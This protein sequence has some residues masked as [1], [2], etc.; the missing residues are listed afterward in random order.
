M[1]LFLAMGTFMTVKAQ[2]GIT[3]SGTSYTQNFD[4]INSAAA[5]PIGWSLSTTAA[6]AA[7]GT[8][9]TA[10]G[11][12]AGSLGIHTNWN[13][14]N[15]NQP[16]N[17]ASASIG[18][19]SDTDAQAAATNRAFGARPAAANDAAAQR[20]AFVL[21]LA[22]TLGFQNFV[23]TFQLQS[24]DVTSP[25][26]L[27]WVVQYSI[28]GGTVWT[29]VPTAGTMTTGGNT[30]SNNAITATFDGGINNV[31]STVHIRI[32]PTGASTGTGNRPT[33]AIDDFVLTF[34]EYIPSATATP[35][36][37]L[38]SG[39]FIGA[40]NVT[41]SSVTPGAEIRFTTDGSTPDSSST[42]FENPIVVAQTTTI[43]AIAFSNDLPESEIAEATFTIRNQG[44]II[45]SQLYTRGGN[46]G[47]TYRGRFVELFNTTNAPIN[48][49]GLYIGSTNAAGMSVTGTALTGIIPAR[50]FFFIESAV[51]GTHADATQD[52]PEDVRDNATRIPGLFNA[53]ADGQVVLSTQATVSFMHDDSLQLHNL[54]GVLDVVSFGGAALRPIGVSSLGTTA[55]ANSFTRNVVNCEFVWTRNSVTGL[56]TAGPP[57]FRNSNHAPFVPTVVVEHN[58]VSD[59]LDLDVAVANEPTLVST[60]T[61]ILTLGCLGADLTL[62]IQ[63][64]SGS[65]FSVYPTSIDRSVFGDTI[66]TVTFAP[67]TVTDFNDA[68]VISGGGLVIPIEIALTGTG[69]S[70]DVPFLRFANHVPLSFGDIIVDGD[71]IRSGVAEINANHLDNDIV[72]TFASTGTSDG[73]HFTATPYTGFDLRDGGLV[74]ITF[75]P[76]TDGELHDTLIITSGTETD[77]LA[78]QGTGIA[79]IASPVALPVTNVDRFSFTANW[80]TVADVASFQ[81]R[82]YEGA[83]AEG[84]PV[85]TLTAADSLTSLAINGLA[86]NTQHTV[87]VVARAELIGNT[88]T[89]NAITFTTLPLGENIIFTF[90]DTTGSPENQIPNVTASAITGMADPLAEPAINSFSASPTPLSGGNNLALMQRTTQGTYAEFTLTPAA[91]YAFTLA[92]VSFGA[93]ATATGPTSWALRS[94]R[95]NFTTDLAT[96][97]IERDLLWASHYALALNFESNVATTFRIYAIGGGA[98][99]TATAHNFRIDDVE[100]GVTT[101]VATSICPREELENSVV[102]FPNPVVD[103]LNI[104]AEQTISMVR[105]Y[106]LS[107]QLV[108]QQQGNVDSVDVSVLPRGTY[109]VRIVF[110]NGAILSRVIVK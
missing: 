34:G 99:A 107:G 96:G 20:N 31:P 11:G 78:L 41:L 37:S 63:S 13:A 103:V 68:L 72:I 6:D 62:S 109:V 2:T 56:F 110:D 49:E 40:Q 1:V 48:L 52:I 70:A 81:I 29:N 88:A 5:L 21:T 27:T 65:V 74:S 105:I 51:A 102:F 45:I 10:M 4:G 106:S 24:L 26:A 33:T 28:N 46:A 18:E 38:S 59:D 104:Q 69:L 79:R 67:D 23:A 3:L 86:P 19:G 22:N 14:T 94:S 7:L 93:R 82:V 85:R 89:S 55:N 100:L 97:T 66:I 61:F 95:D 76:K 92:G 9:V 77:R 58:L 50:G 35:I 39:V 73:T 53:A 36:F 42:L 54:A 75:S 64:G 15:T 47:S 98:S 80:E 12:P 84:E 8:L 91:G 25:R 101:Q 57:T 71:S 43:R 60:E 44:D 83:E 16:R 30:F 32:I 87:V 90:A 17:F 108:V